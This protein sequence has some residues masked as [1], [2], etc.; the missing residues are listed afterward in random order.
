MVQFEKKLVYELNIG[1]LKLIVDGNGPIGAI[2]E[3]QVMSMK[4][5]QNTRR[6]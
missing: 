6:V 2:D 4:V 3:V 5:K 1:A